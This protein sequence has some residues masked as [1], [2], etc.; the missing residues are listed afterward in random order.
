ME[1]E[2][3]RNQVT[4]FEHKSRL[5]E[6]SVRTVYCCSFRKLLKHTFDVIEREFHDLGSYG[7]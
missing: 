5:D 4:D 2:E 1:R 7:A 3:H 6:E